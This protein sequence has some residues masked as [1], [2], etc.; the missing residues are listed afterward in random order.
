MIYLP[1]PKTRVVTISV[2]SYNLWLYNWINLKSQFSSV[3]I[4][5][6]W[7]L[8]FCITTLILTIYTSIL[9]NTSGT[10]NTSLKIQ[11]LQITLGPYHTI[12]IW[13]RTDNRQGKL[14]NPENIKILA[15]CYNRWSRQQ[16]KAVT[17]TIF[18]SAK[19][20]LT[21][22]HCPYARL[23]FRHLFF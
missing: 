10:F 22:N 21:K 16:F 14:Q 3:N 23:H 1:Q 4:R 9:I 15:H 12:L 13:Q 19:K 17:T 8:L 2:E 7:V 6:F 5:V 11:T 20:T 18:S